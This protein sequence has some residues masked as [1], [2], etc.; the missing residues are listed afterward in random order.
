MSMR[1]QNFKYKLIGKLNL[2]VAL[3]AVLSALSLFE[4]PFLHSLHHGVC[5]NHIASP[6]RSSEARIRVKKDRVVYPVI[7]DSCPICSVGGHF[8]QSV[9]LRNKVKLCFSNTAK[10]FA[11]N[12]ILHGIKLI[13]SRQRAPPVV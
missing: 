10:V 6:E 3:M 8:D 7:N 4:M 11:E 5:E 9:P 1:K 13:Y 2:A 12:S